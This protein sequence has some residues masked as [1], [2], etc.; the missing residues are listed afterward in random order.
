MLVCVFPPTARPLCS[1][2]IHHHRWKP[3]GNL[4]SW[5]A[6]S[7]SVFCFAANLLQAHVCLQPGGPS[8]HCY[9]HHRLLHPL[10]T[11][12]RPPPPP[13]NDND[14]PNT[15]FPR[16]GEDGTPVPK[17]RARGPAEASPQPT[18]TVFVA[19]A[20]APTAADD[21]AAFS[22]RRLQRCY[23]PVPR[24]KRRLSPLVLGNT[25]VGHHGGGGGGGVSVV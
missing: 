2:G 7:C 8:R 22:K 23:K 3:G 13:L 16:C 12:P 11:P 21:A 24:G 9:R 19:S 14:E 4:V 15:L 6:T 5:W 25:P 18:R 10:L 20:R 1:L 17:R